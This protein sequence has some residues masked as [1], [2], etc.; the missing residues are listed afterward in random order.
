MQEKNKRSICEVLKQFIMKFDLFGRE[1]DSAHN[2][3]NIKLFKNIFGTVL[4]IIFLGLLLNY[5][6]YKFDNMRRFNDTNILTSQ[7]EN[8]YSDDFIVKGEKGS[9]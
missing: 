1:M 8:F 9:F 2:Y 7:Q 3:A 5:T 6:V 4:S